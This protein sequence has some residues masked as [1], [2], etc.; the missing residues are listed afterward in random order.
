VSV[1]GREK[2]GDGFVKPETGGRRKFVVDRVTRLA[3]DE[4]QS[5][6]RTKVHLHRGLLSNGDAPDILLALPAPASPSSLPGFLRE[7]GYRVEVHDFSTS[8]AL[9][10]LFRVVKARLI[11]LVAVHVSPG[12][13]SLA[14]RLLQLG[15]S[16]G[17][18]V[19]LFGPEAAR[20][21]RIYVDQGADG[22]IAGDTEAGFLAMLDHITEGSVA[23]EAIPGFQ[24]D[25]N[26][27]APAE[28]ASVPLAPLTTAV[29][30]PV[31]LAQ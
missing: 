21:A 1:D 15:H 31:A 25:G 16:I 10:E 13:R 7:H 12:N 6:L 22:V 4:H 26:L 5:L 3:P 30:G 20:E 23:L 17:A 18:R 29:R 2:A 28:R 19:V 27:I 14:I 8:A 24:F 9:N 11:P